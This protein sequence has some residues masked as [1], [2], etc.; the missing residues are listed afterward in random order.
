C[1]RNS[2]AISAP[3]LVARVRSSS[4]DSSAVNSGTSG[5]FDDTL[6]SRAAWAPSVRDFFL[7]RERVRYSMPTRNAFSWRVSRVFFRAAG[8]GGR[9]ACGSAGRNP[10]HLKRLNIRYE[11]C[12]E[13][14]TPF[15]G[16]R[17]IGYR[18]TF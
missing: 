5:A 8:K 7:T 6:L 16:A 9:G 2:P 11:V 15:M 17:S 1:W 13:V 18:V 3:A 4:S 10:V 14:A 12:E